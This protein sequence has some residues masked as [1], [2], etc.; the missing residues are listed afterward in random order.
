MEGNSIQQKS[1]SGEDLKLND[2]TDEINIDSMKK[3]TDQD[4]INDATDSENV[5]NYFWL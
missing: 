2:K 3:S 1:L 4:F 5:I